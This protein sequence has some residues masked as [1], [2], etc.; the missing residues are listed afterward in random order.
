MKKLLK[1]VASLLI[2][3]IVGVL[4]LVGYVRFALPAVDAAPDL[5]IN[6]T[7]EMLK[8]GEYM[9]RNVSG[10]LDCHSVRDAR[11]LTGPVIESTLGKGGQTWGR[12][13][14]LPGNFVAQNLTPAHLKNWTDGEIFRAVTEGVNKDGRPLF[15]IMPYHNYGQIDAED[16]KAIIAYLR[17]LP[18]IP[19]TNPRSEADFPMN[20][21]L[22]TIPKKAT[23]TKRPEE[24]DTLAYGKY[25]VTAAACAECHTPADNR[26]NRLAGMEFAGGFE[27]PLPD[28]SKVRSANITPDKE[29]G[30]GNMTKEQ[31]IARFK[32]YAAAGYQAPEVKP[33]EFNT[34]MPWIFYGGMTEKDLSAIYEY[35][36]TLTPINHRVEKFT[37]EG[38]DK[39]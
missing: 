25:L 18:E 10:C 38:R 32:N 8:R 31:F 39:R 17:T 1:V 36:R 4:G 11:R 14:G 2:L 30:I 3:L 6:A 21:I 16:V 23:F 24:T 12:E 26:G 35:L 20:F 9:A 7:P 27:F 5:K 33:G 37:T 13:E 34:V 19:D 28:G 22:R 29:T 15:P